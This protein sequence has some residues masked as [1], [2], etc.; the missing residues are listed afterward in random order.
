MKTAKMYKTGQV[1]GA[2][3]MVIGTGAVV[4][5]LSSYSNRTKAQRKAKEIGNYLVEKVNTEK[6]ILGNKLMEMKQKP[7][8]I[9]FDMNGPLS[10]Y[11]KKTI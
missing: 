10:R 4:G 5:F 8:D 6:K 1:V 2:I 9:G 11:N 7:R 3:L